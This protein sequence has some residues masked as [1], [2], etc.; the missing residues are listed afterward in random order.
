MSPA[1]PEFLYRYCSAERAVQVLRD[2]SLYLCPPADFN[3]LYE[4]TIA[5]LTQYDREAALVLVSKFA[6]IRQGVSPKVARSMLGERMPEAE[7]KRTFRD[8]A[9]WLREPAEK[10]R[11]NSGVTCFSTRR[12]DQHMWGTYGVNHTGVCIE[13][14]NRSGESE[15]LRRAQ[16]V[17][18]KNGSLADKLPDLFN[19]DLGLDIHRLALWC[20]FVK[21]TDWRDEREWRVF[22]LSMQPLTTIQRLL[23]FQPKDVRRVFCGPR[24]GTDPRKE[25][26]A[27]ASKSDCP[28]ALLDL[29]PDV[30]AGFT[31]FDGVDVLEFPQDFTYW[32]PE[33]FAPQKR[34]NDDKDDGACAQAQPF[35][36]ADLHRQGTWAARSP[37]RSSCTAWPR[38][39]A[40]GGRSAQTLG[41]T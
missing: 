41:S 4:G 2:N 13:F 10:L 9:T 20:Y 29:K 36:R 30:H 28:W 18:Y 35:A 8:V 31:Q 15:I 22:T 26:S 16:P 3:D 27:L 1:N 25:L 11:L 39:L 32:F 19:N 34:P 37:L 7:I 5:R 6:T 23:P 17:L 21:S 40:G 33:A 12:D 38:R 24:M 14:C